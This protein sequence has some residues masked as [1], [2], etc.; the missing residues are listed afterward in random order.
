MQLAEFLNFDSES[1]RRRQKFFDLI[2]QKQKEIK[3]GH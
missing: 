3:A 1:I 2:K